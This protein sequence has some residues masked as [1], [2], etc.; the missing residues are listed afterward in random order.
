M[1]EKTY[2]R[3]NQM[4]NRPTAGKE[5]P[6][7]QMSAMSGEHPVTKSSSKKK[8]ESETCDRSTGSSSTTAS[9]LRSYKEMGGG[10]T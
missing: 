5:R 6:Q 4:P 2:T 7:R 1:E 10:H 8:Q 9:W 3:K